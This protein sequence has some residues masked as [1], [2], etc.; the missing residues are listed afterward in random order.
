ML[1]L[2]LVLSFVVTGFGWLDFLLQNITISSNLDQA[3]PKNQ[4]KIVIF[5]NFC[6]TFQTTPICVWSIVQRKLGNVKYMYNKKKHKKSNEHTSKWY[7]MAQHSKIAF[8][9]PLTH[10]KKHILT[11]SFHLD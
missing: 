9:E 11:L 8:N 4:N 2:L 5:F 1:L 6:Q 3:K 10:N 7:G